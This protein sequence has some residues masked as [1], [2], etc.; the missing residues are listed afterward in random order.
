M[1]WGFRASKA[2][3]DLLLRAPMLRGFYT[4]LNK[5]AKQHID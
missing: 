3:E 2:K 5:A 1:L 4:G